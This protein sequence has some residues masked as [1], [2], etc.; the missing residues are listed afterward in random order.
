MAKAPTKKG[1]LQGV[2]SLNKQSTV[3]SA[4]HEC[5]ELEQRGIDHARRMREAA[6]V[7]RGNQSWGWV[8]VQ[9]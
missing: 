7:P 1:I 4:R 2:R 5:E 6:A 8:D 3:E 9:H